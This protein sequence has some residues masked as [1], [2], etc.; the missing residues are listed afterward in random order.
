MD[1]VVEN[2]CLYSNK[3]KL[4]PKGWYS[5]NSLEM[6]EA[7]EVTQ[8][9][10]GYSSLLDVNRGNISIDKHMFA[11][12]IVLYYDLMNKCDAFMNFDILIK[13][14]NDVYI[15]LTSMVQECGMEKLLSTTSEVG[16]NVCSQVNQLGKSGRFDS[17]TSVLLKN[18]EL[19]VRGE[20]CISNMIEPAD[21]LDASLK[22]DG[23]GIYNNIIFED[24]DIDGVDSKFW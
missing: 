7:E 3:M 8:S 12:F 1:I 15:Y 6:G 9:N 10:V 14:L 24:E 20:F 13:F 22:E 16:I 11:Y 18:A 5:M 23:F 17:A 21:S 2:E 4:I 19:D